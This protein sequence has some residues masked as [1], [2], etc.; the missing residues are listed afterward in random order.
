MIDSEGNKEKEFNEKY[1]EEENNKQLDDL[2]NNSPVFDAYDLKKMPEDY[3]QFIFNVIINKLVIILLD[4]DSKVDTEIPLAKLTQNKITA[5]AKIGQ[6]FQDITVGIGSIFIRDFVVKSEYFPYLVQTI[7]EE[8]K[9]QNAIDLEFHNHPKFEGGEMKLSLI[10]NAKLYIFMNPILLREIEEFSDLGDKPEDKIDLSYYT[11]K[12]T[13]SV[14]EYMNIGADYL[15]KASEEQ[16][17]APFSSIY[18]NLKVEAPL[19]FVPE[20]IKVIKKTK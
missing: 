4:E 5:H 19:I 20:D 2:M 9:D 17:Q 6:D 11:E 16:E 15:E 1:A 8:G 13:D 3:I 10:T 18:L 14:V 7:F 12:A